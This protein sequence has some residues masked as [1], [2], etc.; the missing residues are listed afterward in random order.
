[1]GSVIGARLEKSAPSA[2]SSSMQRAL[3]SGG[4]IGRWGGG[5]ATGAAAARTQKC[6]SGDR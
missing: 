2:R 5:F 6:V 1:M 3:A 4:N